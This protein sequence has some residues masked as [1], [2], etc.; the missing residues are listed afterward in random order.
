MTRERLADGP[1]V[2]ICGSAGES[3]AHAAYVEWLVTRDDG[4]QEVERLLPSG[5]TIHIPV[6]PRLTFADADARAARRGQS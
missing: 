1:P 3:K 4:T 5:E 6:A 2:I